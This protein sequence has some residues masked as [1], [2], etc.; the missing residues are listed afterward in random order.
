MSLDAARVWR[1]RMVMVTAERHA[2][3]ALP[4]VD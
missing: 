1:G 4:L 3:G 2:E